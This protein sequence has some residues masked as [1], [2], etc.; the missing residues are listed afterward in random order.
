MEL[1]KTTV[2]TNGA[3]PI[4]CDTEAIAAD[5]R[6]AHAGA[7]DLLI[8]ACLGFEEH[9]DAVTFRYPARPELLATAGRWMGLER[10]CCAFL[11][12]ALRAPAGSDEFELRIG[13]RD[14][15]KAFVL[16]NMVPARS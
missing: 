9:A 1:L 12:F 11:D 7:S 15:A 2:S 8:E 3:I 14:G 6:S 16:A 10:Q 5:D 4:A 13:G